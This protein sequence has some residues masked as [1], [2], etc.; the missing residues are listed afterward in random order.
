MSPECNPDTA[1]AYWQ[2]VRRARQMTGEERMLEGVRMFDRECER[3]RQEILKTNPNFSE[4]DVA[5]EIRRR[6]DEAD[7][8]GEASHY[9]SIPSPSNR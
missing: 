9:R 5:K 8:A 6:L 1:Q 2:R 4:A 7:A 3:V